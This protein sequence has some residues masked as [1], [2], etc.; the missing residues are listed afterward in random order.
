[1]TEMARLALAA[2]LVAALG[3]PAYAGQCEDDVRKIQAALAK[4]DLSSDQR[5]QIADMAAQAKKL[6]AAGHQP[7]GLDVTSEAK[8][9]LNIQ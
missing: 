6:C 3:V 8:A 4:S 7:E 5:A 1:M 9:M 2:V